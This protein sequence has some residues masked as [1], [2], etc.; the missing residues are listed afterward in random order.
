MHGARIKP[1]FEYG[2]QKYNSDNSDK[3]FSANFRAVYCSY[4]MCGSD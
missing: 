1:E 3:V 4:D 2:S